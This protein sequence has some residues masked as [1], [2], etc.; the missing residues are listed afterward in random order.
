MFHCLQIANEILLS[1]GWYCKVSGE[2]GK[3][4]VVTGVSLFQLVSGGTAHFQV[5]LFRYLWSSDDEDKILCSDEDKIPCS[6]ED[7]ILCS[8]EEEILCWVEEEILYG[9]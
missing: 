6:D 3:F 1:S 7:K 8:D 4:N 9:G 2:T 5:C